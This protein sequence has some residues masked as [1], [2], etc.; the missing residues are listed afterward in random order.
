MLQCTPIQH[1]NHKKKKKKKKKP[2]L[3]IDSFLNSSVGKEQTC[4]CESTLKA[5]N[6]VELMFSS[7]HSHPRWANT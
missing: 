5:P 2:F 1:N 6:A 4:M 3:S 7:H